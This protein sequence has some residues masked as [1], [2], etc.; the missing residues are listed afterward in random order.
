MSPS[1]VLVTRSSTVYVSSTET[2]T[3]DRHPDGGTARVRTVMTMTTTTI[4]IT[5]T[6]TTAT[7][8][9]DAATTDGGSYATSPLRRSWRV[10]AVVREASRS[11]L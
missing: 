9:A 6:V 4:V 7:A 8:A 11:S 3:E 2:T 1:L 10:A 5:V